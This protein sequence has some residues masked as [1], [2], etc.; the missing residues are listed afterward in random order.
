M[1]NKSFALYIDE[2]CYVEIW[3]LTKNNYIL[4]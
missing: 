1:N 4:K 3:Y 2:I